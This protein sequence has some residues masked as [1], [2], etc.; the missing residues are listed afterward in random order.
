MIKEILDRLFPPKCHHEWDILEKTH[1]VKTDTKAV[2]GTTFTLR[3]K[4]CGDIKFRQNNIY[5]D[6]E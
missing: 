5:E 3:C 1:M 4:K 2:I 6:Y